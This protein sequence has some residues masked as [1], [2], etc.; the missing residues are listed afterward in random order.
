MKKLILLNILILTAAFTYQGP[1][2]NDNIH[3]WAQQV[4]FETFPD[5][6]SGSYDI[7]LVNSHNRE[8]NYLSAKELGFE[9]DEIENA[10]AI[11]LNG[12]EW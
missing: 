5:D 11:I 9:S 6:L 2:S 12:Q 1:Y 8:G 3:K 4:V 10:C 7:C